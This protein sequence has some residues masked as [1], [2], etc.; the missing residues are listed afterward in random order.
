MSNKSN[1]QGRAYEFASITTLHKA[2]SKERENVELVYNSSYKAS[3]TA[4]GTLSKEEQT[5]YLL[6][7]ESTIDTIFSLEPRI[8]ENSTDK[9]QLYIQSDSKGIEA[10]V[11]DII[12]K[13]DVI[14]WEI[15]LSIKHNH[16]AVKHS[17]L[18]KKR[19]FGDAWYGVKCS[20]EYWTE[21]KPIFDFLEEEKNK[22]KYFRDI[23]NKEDII[24]I[25]L[26]NAFI[27]EVKRAIK[28]DKAIPTKLVRYLLSKYDFYKIISIDKERLTTIQSF[29]M[30]GTLNQASK[31]EEPK[32]IT[33]K[34]NL[35]TDL[36]FIGLKKGS[37]NTV[38]ACFDNGWQF[39]FRIHNA[40]DLV[41][42]SL[43]F[44]IQII[45]MPIEVNIKYNC[46]W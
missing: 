4:W 9:L 26:L 45:G 34:I 24:Y 37:K 23:E 3:E 25:P 41:E 29:N 10:D 11:R 40:K 42:T 39:S 6:S 2:I 18:S 12:I 19:D 31:Y 28:V 14:I 32:I 38:I 13:R 16:T 44:D 8:I 21:I 46:K 22:K 43:K 7:A 15:G 35:P 20:K 27:N 33:Q 5:L 17:R 36:L 30:Y 1:N